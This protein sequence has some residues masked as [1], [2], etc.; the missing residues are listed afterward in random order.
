MTRCACNLGT[1]SYSL[2]NP[3]DLFVIPKTKEMPEAAV[4]LCLGND[5][6]NQCVHALTEAASPASSGVDLWL[7][8][9]LSLPCRLTLRSR[10]ALHSVRLPKMLLLSLPQPV[11][12][13]RAER[14]DWG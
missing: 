8:C 9:T 4:A 3:D 1:P 11:L 7:R 10:G 5:D 12:R 14:A 13:A 6:K 2:T